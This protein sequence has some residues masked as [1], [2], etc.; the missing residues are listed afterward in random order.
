MVPKGDMMDNSRVWPLAMSLGSGE[1][2]QEVCEGLNHPQSVL[3]SQRSAL[4]TTVVVLKE[5]EV[6]SAEVSEQCRPHRAGR[7]GSPASLPSSG[8]GV[9][10][11]LSD[12]STHSPVVR[13]TLQLLTLQDAGPEVPEKPLGDLSSLSLGSND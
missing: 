1:C 10:C 13:A 5:R 4:G 7:V 9:T 3:R 8:P 12:A 11:P 6:P 2:K